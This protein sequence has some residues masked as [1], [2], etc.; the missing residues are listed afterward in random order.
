MDY[1]KLSLVEL[2]DLA[3]NHRPKIKHYYIK[4]R[5]ELIDIL[6]MDRLPDSLIMQKKTIAELR[7]EVRSKGYTNIWKLR[8]AELVELLYSSPEKNNH[9]D[10]HAKKHDDPQEGE[11]KQVRI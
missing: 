3:K 5:Q 10:D 1:S 2:K 9:N 6:S 7:K 4:T 11:S 8:R